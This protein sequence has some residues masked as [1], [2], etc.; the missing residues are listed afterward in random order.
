MNLYRSLLQVAAGLAVVAAAHADS[1][2]VEIVSVDF[3]H[4]LRSG[5][6]SVTCTLK[7]IGS[8]AAHVVA[9]RAI[10]TQAVDDTGLTL[11]QGNDPSFFVTAVGSSQGDHSETMS[12][13]APITF[14]LS[15]A[16]P[17][18]TQLRSVE[19][20]VEVFIPEKDADS[21]VIVAPLAPKLGTRI[22]SPGLKA[23]GVTLV[24]YD[25]ASLEPYRTHDGDDAPQQFDAGPWFITWPRREPLFPD[26]PPAAQTSVMETLREHAEEMPRTII[27]V[28]IKD[29]RGRLLPVEFQDKAG[30]P[31]RYNHNG[32]YHSSGQEG[33]RFDGY[34]LGAPLPPDTRMVCWI[35][36]DKTL[37]SAPFRLSNVPLPSK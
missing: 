37:V 28:G 18:A 26:M 27:G 31:L 17:G 9:A 8:D 20:R 16:G 6:K 29:P 30:R 14:G 23:T 2:Q 7:L 4:N 25:Q 21:L 3:I 34:D 32:S 12:Q 13:Q 36:T 22:E 10:V 19:G 1:I 11:K 15:P 5:T 33:K 35:I 24:V